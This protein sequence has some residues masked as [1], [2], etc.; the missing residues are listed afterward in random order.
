MPKSGRSTFTLAGESVDLD[1]NDMTKGD[2]VELQ[3]QNKY[4]L[5]DR[6]VCRHLD[7]EQSRGQALLYLST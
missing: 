1:S 6:D 3:P 5:E 7:T 4:R 2:N